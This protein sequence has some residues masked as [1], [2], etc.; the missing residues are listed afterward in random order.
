MSCNGWEKMRL[1]DAFLF[2]PTERLAKG[3]EAKKVTMDKLQPFTRNIGDYELAPY[4]GG[5]K[6]RN[7]DTLMARITPCL[8]NGKT[9]WVS[10]LDDNEVGFGST[11]YIV[12]RAKENV[13]DSRFVYYFTTNP[14]F[15]D[16][17]VKS[18]VGS[19]GRQRVQQ[20]VLENLEVSIPPLPIQRRIAQI[21]GSLDDKIE[22]NRQINDNLERR[23]FLYRQ[24]AGDQFG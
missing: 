12:L 7:G 8:E 2:N 23:D 17:A 4:A 15:R 14:W 21:L 18:M 24:L 9:A 16:I 3:V 20:S 5:A 19:S 1:G 10:I 6:F 22:L 11:E 13:T